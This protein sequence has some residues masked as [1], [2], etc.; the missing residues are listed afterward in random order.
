MHISLFFV[1]VEIRAFVH[2]FFWPAKGGGGP[3]WGGIPATFIHSFIA[4]FPSPFF[5]LLTERAALDT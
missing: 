1:A 5:L 4:T 3:V 2:S